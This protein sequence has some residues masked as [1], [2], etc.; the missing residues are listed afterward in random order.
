MNYLELSIVLDQA[1]NC[2]TNEI[3]A[4]IVTAELA[5]MEFESFVTEGNYLKCYIQKDLWNQDTFDENEYLASLKSELKEIEQQNWNAEWEKSFSP[6]LVEDKCI[7][8]AS[9]QEVPEGISY[10]IIIDPKMSFGTGH[11]ETTYLMCSFLMDEEVKSK[12]V[13]DMGCGTGVLAILAAKKNAG[14]VEAIDIDNW[15]YTNTLENIRNN[16]TADIVV[17]EGGA[18]HLGDTHFDIILANINRNILLQDMEHYIQNLNDGGS[19]FLSGFYEQD[20]P[21]LEEKANSLG[22]EIVDSK[23]KNHWTSLKLIKI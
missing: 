21:T 13:L 17:K 6:I 14:Y 11:H 18:E 4:D 16:N 15:A 3:F 5:E 1:H 10:D 22:M 7:I 23:V 20:I 19:L 12:K 2:D 9:F 8:R